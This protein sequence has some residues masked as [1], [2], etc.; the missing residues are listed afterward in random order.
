MTDTDLVRYIEAEIIPRYEDFDRAH[1]TDH[2]RSVIARSLDLA[3]RLGADADMAYTV[4]AYHDT[5]LAIERERHHLISGEI[6][7]RDPQ[8]PR[9]FDAPRI[10]MMREAVEDHRA[11]AERAPRSLYGC[12]VAEADRQLDPETVLRRTVQYGLDR[13]PGL[14]REGQY[15]RMRDHLMRKY[16]DGGYLRIW[17]PESDN[18]RRLDELRRLLRDEGRLRDAFGRLYDEAV[19]ATAP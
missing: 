6:L 12:I 19:R 9:W 13:T 8:L 1:R 7:A 14:D 2:V 18:A 17:L 16:G 11:S 4:A 10:R 5:G 15:L 3:R